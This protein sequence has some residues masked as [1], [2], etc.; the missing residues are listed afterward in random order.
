MNL[1]D[2]DGVYVFQTKLSAD[3]KV[4]FVATSEDT[5][6]LVKALVNAEPDKNLLAFRE[7]MS[8]GEFADV[9]GRTLGVKSKYIPV[10]PKDKWVDMPDFLA[11]D[12]EECAAYIDEFG[13]DGGDPSVIHPKDVSLQSWIE[14]SISNRD[15]STILFNSAVWRTGFVGKTGAQ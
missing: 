7:S 14:G 8:F 6:P 11:I 9:W 2:A 5:G 4:P 15:S 10:D 1:Q 12:I 13:Y 3:C